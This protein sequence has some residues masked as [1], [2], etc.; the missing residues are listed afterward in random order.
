MSVAR[1]RSPLAH[2]AVSGVVKGRRRF[3][4]FENEMSQ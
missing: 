2:V 4:A 3:V 1:V